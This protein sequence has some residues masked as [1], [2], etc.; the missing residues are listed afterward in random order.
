M[1]AEALTDVYL[2]RA[3]CKRRPRKLLLIVCGNNCELLHIVVLERRKKII[4]RLILKGSFWFWLHH[5]SFFAVITIVAVVTYIIKKCI[6]C[7]STM[8][9]EIRAP[10]GAIPSPQPKP[11]GL[12][13][14]ILSVSWCIYRAQLIIICAFAGA[15][16]KP[17]KITRYALVV[18]KPSPH[19]EEIQMY[20]HVR[21]PCISLTKL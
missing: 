4:Y 3:V 7:S 1:A 11:F 18:L 5:P 16:K 12:Q 21:F 19:V 2:I 14:L 8:D 9:V 17:F 13:W 10:P 15:N 6:S 20:F